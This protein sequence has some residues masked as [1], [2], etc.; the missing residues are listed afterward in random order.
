MAKISGCTIYIILDNVKQLLPLQLPWGYEKKCHGWCTWIGF[1]LMPQVPS[2][3]KNPNHTSLNENYVVPCIC[4]TAIWHMHG[5]MWH[6]TRMTRD[7]K[8]IVLSRCDVITIMLCQSFNVEIVLKV[9]SV[10]TPAI[11]H[12]HV[13][14]SMPKHS[15][16]AKVIITNSPVNNTATQLEKMHG[17]TMEREV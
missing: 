3:K 13:T 9:I 6:A 8:R 5:S 10:G 17:S 14:I 15:S 2:R 16:P 12:I 4:L 11:R 7:R 1:T